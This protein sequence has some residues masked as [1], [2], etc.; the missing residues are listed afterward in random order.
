MTIGDVICTDLFQKK[1]DARLRSIE[2]ENARLEAKLPTGMIF[3]KHPYDRLCKDNAWNVSA[4]AQHFAEVM[5]KS[6]RLPA[7]TREYVIQ[8]C[9]PILLTTIKELKENGTDK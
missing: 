8:V 5:N 6:S 1:L 3:T 2:R 7:A 4:M 9:R